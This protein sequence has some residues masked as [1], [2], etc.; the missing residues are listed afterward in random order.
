[1]VIINHQPSTRLPRIS[2]VTPSYNQGPY[3]EETIRSV[4]DQGYPNLEYIVMDGGSTDNSVAIIRK[5]ESKLSFWVS[6]KDRG[7]SDA[8]NRGWERSDGD[9]LAYLNSDDAYEPGVLDSVTEVFRNHPEADLV[10]GDYSYMD[11]SGRVYASFRTPE[12]DLATLVM[13]NYISQ[14]T[15][16]LR[17]GLWQRIGPLNDELHYVMDFDYWIRAAVAGARFFPNSRP[18]ARM[19][20]HSVSKTFGSEHRSWS[21]YVQV[22]ETFFEREQ[23]APGLLG[24]KSRALARAHWTA[25]VFLAEAGEIPEARVQAAK[26]M[27][28]YEVDHR[29]ED[30]DLVL[31][32]LLHQGD[33]L[34]EGHGRLRE[35]AAVGR[36]LESLDLPR[37]YPR[38]HQVVEEEYMKRWRCGMQ[39]ARK[40]AIIGNVLQAIWARPARIRN[41]ALRQTVREA[42]LGGGADAG[43][44]RTKRA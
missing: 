7:Q 20:I 35:P 22:L 34:H 12:V 8:I 10:Y 26:G 27:A 1:M 25:A 31:R 37:R 30:L 39:G 15:V 11:S 41:W 32:Y 2:I 3:I 16:F 23:M 21:E 4:L 6:E 44:H 5:Y 42:F 13:G 43:G 28:A 33:G 24:M 40:T 29:A 38:F 19:R 17:R 9:I 36:I 18:H 14:P